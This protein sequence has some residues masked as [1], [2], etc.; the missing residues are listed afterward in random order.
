MATLG[1][2]PASGGPMIT[3]SHLLRFSLCIGAG[4]AAANATAQATA[5]AATSPPATNAAAQQD[6][7]PTP[8]FEQ[9]LVDFRQR[10]LAAGIEPTTLDTAFAG[11][12]PDPSV[13]ALDQQQPEFTRYLW[14]YL[15]DRVTPSAIQQGQQLL[16]S[17]RALFQ[18]VAAAV[19]CGSGHPDGHLE[20]GKRVRQTDRRPLRDPFAGDAGA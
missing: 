14:D 1:S 18:K 7:A 8:S 19:R 16:V 10:A 6:A 13:Q 15:D 3:P 20:H 17:Q 4:V 12:T 11:V 9:W 5:P 2:H